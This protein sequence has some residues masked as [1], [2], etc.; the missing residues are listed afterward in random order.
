MPVSI[1]YILRLAVPMIGEQFL[2]FGIALFDTAVAGSLGIV[3][4]SA[5]SVVVR[6]VQFTTV[7]YNIMS[8]GGSILVAQAVGQ[9]RLDHA[10]NYLVGALT[11]SLAAGVALTL[12]VLLLSPALVGIMGVDASVIALGV[13]YLS[14]IAWSFPFNFLLLSAAGCVRGAGDART[15]LLVLAAANVVHVILVITL[16][17]DAGLGLQGIALATII[18]RLLG[19][20]AFAFLLVRGVAGLKLARVQ[21]SLPAM[22]NIWRVGSAV[23]GEQLA[24]RL[25]QLVNLRLVATLGTQLVAAYSVVINTVSILLTI[26]IGFMAASLTIVGQLI[27]AGDAERVYTTG[28]RILYL[29]WGVVGSLCLLFFLY[30]HINALFASDPETL[31]IAALGL[32]VLLISVPFELVNQVI[33]GALRGSGDTG[34]PMFL[35]A[36]GHWV[37]R[38]PLIALL[39]GVGKMGLNGVWLAMIVETVVR[40]A[41]NLRRFQPSLMPEAKPE[42]H[43]L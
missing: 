13:P 7:I 8:V 2:V 32:R 18:S 36:L 17:R 40:A 35:T 31:D 37:I 19:C 42:M 22:R 33:T 10:D 5:Q 30:P 6:W 16:V 34:Y 43:L 4:I 3:A 20:A 41:L 39:V 26:G 24:L 25:G 27:G 11:L 28:W 9:K 23:G 14:L 21:P 1:G 12:L 15:P 38:L 29:G